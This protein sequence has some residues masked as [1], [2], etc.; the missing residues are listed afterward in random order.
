MSLRL[1]SR[2]SQTHGYYYLCDK[3]LFT[4]NLHLCDSRHF[5]PDYSAKR[6]IMFHYHYSTRYLTFLLIRWNNPYLHIIMSLSSQIYQSPNNSALPFCSIK[7]LKA[8]YFL[9]HV[10]YENRTTYFPSLRVH[11]HYT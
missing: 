9:L 2:N 10:A 8:V 1:V 4:P 6:K 7:L 3:L 5:Q 11:G